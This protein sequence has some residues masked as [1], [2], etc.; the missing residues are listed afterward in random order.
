M[1]SLYDEENELQEHKFNPLAT[2]DSHF[3]RCKVYNRY[4]ATKRHLLVSE[5]NTWLLIKF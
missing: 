1:A 5:Q 4:A 3:M 2:N